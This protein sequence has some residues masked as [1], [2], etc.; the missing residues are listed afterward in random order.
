M[1]IE[2]KLK[3]YDSQIRLYAVQVSHFPKFDQNIFSDSL[4][5]HIPTCTSYASSVLPHH[6]CITFSKKGFALLRMTALVK[7]RSMDD[8]R[9]QNKALCE[10]D[11]A[12]QYM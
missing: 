8:D 6:N 9:A 5:L 1:M 7:A 11:K 2:H 10:S 4:L 12:M 3:H